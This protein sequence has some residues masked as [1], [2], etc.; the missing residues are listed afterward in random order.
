M[1]FFAQIWVNYRFL[2]NPV[3]NNLINL[4]IILIHK[5][6]GERERCGG[7]KTSNDRFKNIF[8]FI[9]IQQFQIKMIIVTTT[10][11]IIII[12]IDPGYWCVTLPILFS[13]SKML[14]PGPS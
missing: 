7:W 9:L 5:S 1:S 6:F 12:I 14:L 11:I 4:C 10:T 2:I 13:K 8:S 3:Y